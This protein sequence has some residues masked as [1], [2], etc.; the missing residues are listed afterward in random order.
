MSDQRMVD[1][2]R[3]QYLKTAAVAG[4]LA[5]LGG[6]TGSETSPSS[7]QLGFST[8]FTSGAWVSALVD[9]TEYYAE[10]KEFEYNLFTTGGESQQQISD[11]RQMINQGYDGIILVP[12]NTQE[13]ASVVEEAA[14]EDIPVFTLDIGAATEET[15]MHVSWSDEN[16]AQR[17]AE[18]LIEELRNQ[19]PNRDDYQVLEVRAP[20][21]RDISR[22][23]HEPFVQRIAET[24]DVEVAGTIVGDWA[25]EA[26]D[27]KAR[28]WI[29][30][31]EAPDAVYSANFAMGLGA[32]RALNELNLRYPQGHEDHVVAVQLDGSSQTH[33]LINEGYIDAAIDQPVHYYGPIAIEYFERYA[34]G[35]GAEE[36]PDVG[37]EVTSDDLTI[38]PAERDGTMLWDEPLWAPATIGESFDHTHFVANMIEITEENADSSQLWGNNW[39]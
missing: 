20:P 13:I 18:R 3:R 30:A 33:Q 38:E 23:R 5:S 36:L 35:D 9:G 25:R 10:Q 19:H 7:L 31:N 11:M 34:T 8:H 24:D 2:T 12:F 32:M 14:A 22:L 6:C 27:Q 37:S 1:R 21:G 39:G 16:A 17:A 15:A 26:A 29:N 4:T 28:E